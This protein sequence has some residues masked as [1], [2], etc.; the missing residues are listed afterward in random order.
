MVRVRYESIWLIFPCF[1]DGFIR[2]EATQGLEA[3]HKIVCGDEVAKMLPELGVRL[4][5]EALTVVAP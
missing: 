5:M 4:V 3:P 2:R 1:A